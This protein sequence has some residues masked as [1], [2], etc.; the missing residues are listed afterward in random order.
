MSKKIVRCLKI[1]GNILLY[2]FFAVCLAGIVLSVAAKKD[3]DGAATV[4]GYQ[5]RFVRSDSMEKSE[6]TDV[7]GFDIG[8]IPVKSMLFIQTVPTDATKAEKWYE[9]LQVGD[10]L[11][12]RYVYTSAVTIT[13]RLV[14]KQPNENGGYTLLLEGDNKTGEYSV[15]QQT[16]DTSDEDSPNYVI[17]KVVGQS[18]PIGLLV[19]ALKSPLGIVLI[20]I[21]PCTIVIAM[22]I[23]RIVSAL[24]AEKRE[25]EKLERE[26][27]EDEIEQLKRKLAA[28]E[29]AALDKEVN[30]EETKEENEG[31]KDG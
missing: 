10:V 26:A 30:E 25:K 9:E 6:Y 16:I 21:V 19:Y 1:I 18:Y 22:E 24:N 13:H 8:S 28:L 15:L 2:T 14:D 29:N 23:A 11:T 27:K 20:V 4:F 31:T 3:E 12:F 5:M 7:S 17:G